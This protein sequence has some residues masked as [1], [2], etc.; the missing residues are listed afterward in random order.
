MIQTK[1]WK[2]G[3]KVKFKANIYTGTKKD[4]I[5]VLHGVT[6]R[7]VIKQLSEITGHPVALVEVDLPE[8]SIIKRMQGVPIEH[9]EEV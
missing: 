9:L 5:E 8:E 1:E 7:G 4:P 3:D 2:K 6:F